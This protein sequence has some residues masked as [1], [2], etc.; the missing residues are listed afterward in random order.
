[1]SRLVTRLKR[2]G[3]GRARQPATP[4]A[5][6][7]LQRLRAAAVSGRRA[8]PVPA[9]S[10]VR[11]AVAL[12]ERL[13]LGLA[14]EWRQD[15]LDPVSWKATV[16]E[17]RPD[18]VLL[19]VVD[20]TVPNWGGLDGAGL[21]EL[22]TWSRDS[23]VPVLIW[24]TAG[25]VFP[26]AGNPV[27]EAASALYVADPALVS[28]W[29]DRFPD[30]RV[31]LLMPAAQP[32]L[33]NP[34][35][36]GSG[37]PRLAAAVLIVEAAGA[38]VDES[39][40][41]VVASA[42]KPMAMESLDVWQVQGVH[43]GP[44]LPEPLMARNA[45]SV[46][47]I[48]A[49]SIPARYN[50]L[51]HG[52]RATNASTWAVVEAAS[53]QTP[54]VTLTALHSSLP[55]DLSALVA[56]ASDSRSLRSEIVARIAQ[57]E[58]RDREGLL[59]HRA[60]LDAHT[61]SHRVDSMLASIQQHEQPR[62]RTI[63]AVVP[64]NRAHEI[65]NILENVG[66]QVDVDV[67]LLLVLHGLSL[68]HSEI[69][70]R[71]RD[72][73]VETIR[74]I[75]AEAG[76]TLGACLNLG[77]DAAGG[78]YIAKMDDDNFYGRHYLKDLVRAFDFTDAGIVGKWAHYV[79]LRTS[80]AVVLRYA[81]AEH[82]YERRVQGGSML[83][84]GDLARRLRFADLPRAVDSDILDRA[85]AEGVRI[86]SSDRVNFVSVRSTDRNA[87]TWTVSDAT[88]MTASGRLMFFGD[89]RIHVDV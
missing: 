31:D 29:R 43:P 68:D 63:S 89:P 13:R 80:G 64:T 49:A 40:Q 47:R 65:D 79:W 7:R 52:G 16:A 51:V 69:V 58:L 42:V 25:T 11:A 6:A 37:E 50:V 9:R 17:R 33:H 60:V 54:T 36:V 39:L 24:V 88:F 34:A 67:E 26:D 48:T 27:I 82:T 72:R 84:D 3:R 21:A 73:G 32:R 86:Y 10:G 30:V 45:G 76:R 83:L 55:E 18:L 14:W 5:P 71:A 23:S 59:M 2:L 15:E 57:S 78:G 85:M 8:A 4:T 1:M 44:A 87:H 61:Y 19:E 35:T 38:D 70:A 77:V 81:D 74:I 46:T 22:A 12:S 56:A 66:R 28:A 62:G 53:A 20:G 75:E 41:T